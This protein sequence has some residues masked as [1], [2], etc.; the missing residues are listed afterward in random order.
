MQRVQPIAEEDER[1]DRRDCDES[2]EQG[3]FDQSLSRL[4]IAG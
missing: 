2:E 4:L 3:V 1:G